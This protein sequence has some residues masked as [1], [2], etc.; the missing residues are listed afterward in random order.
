MTGFDQDR[1]FTLMELVAVMA[2]VG[3]L[4][5]FA[6]AMF[7]RQAFDTARFARE[8][9]AVLAYAQKSAVAQRRNVGVAV[10]SGA[11]G[12]TICPAFD[13]CVAPINLPLPTQDGGASLPVP[14]GVT[15]TATVGG[16]AAGLPI[17]FSFTPL[18]GIDR[19]RL[20]LTA[21]GEVSKS[22]VVE[23]DTGYVY[24]QP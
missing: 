9:E 13:S 24:G 19:P 7:N 12:F 5:V 21:N 23:S 8:L 20:V 10:G 6:A 14:A 18:G 22:V 2:I 11:V 3:I 17:N 4:S 1:G 16:G 15:L